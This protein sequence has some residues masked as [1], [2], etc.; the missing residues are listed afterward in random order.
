MFRFLD[1]VQDFGS[2]RTNHL[3]D[4]LTYWESARSK[5]S[6]T[7][8]ADTDALRITTIHKSKGLEYPVVI[9]PYANWKF[10]P[11]AILDRLWVDLDGV[12]YEELFLPGAPDR[13]GVI[14]K[15]RSTMVS[16]QKELENTSIADQYTDEK[17]RKLVETMN[18][19]YVAF[20]RPVQRLYIL[21]KKEKNWNA[22]PNVGMWLH[23]Y[24]NQE[25]FQ[26]A[27][28]E[29]KDLY[30][31]YEG[32]G[33]C[34]H[35]HV[36]SDSEPLVMKEILSNDR[37]NTLRL[38]RMADRIFDI[39]TF[40][41]KHDRLQKV[42][43]LLTRLKSISD[44]SDTLTRLISEGIFTRNE[45]R[46]IQE[47][48]RYLLENPSLKD[49]YHDSN[50]LSINKDLLIPGGKLLHIDRLVKRPNGEYVFMSFV[51]GNGGDEHR[52]HLR[53]LIQ[54]FKN[55]GKS[56]SGVMVTLE[57]EMVEWV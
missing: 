52:R 22:S 5:L 8:P 12:P 39:E 27:W 19:L 7:I 11:N 13:N 35:A 16:V 17:T 1:V 34:S 37:T 30:V 54:A 53:K 50:E 49:L 43:Y 26:P 40:E 29:T 2:R 57:N 23:D 20:T 44:M 25:D 56:S 21:A 6:I 3:G 55:T 36:R 41:P 47:Q 28:E 48:V 31:L 51:G 10:T 32:M 42:R 45:A 18:L 14:G 4:F 9:V 33:K 38:R 46:S 15:L 24:L